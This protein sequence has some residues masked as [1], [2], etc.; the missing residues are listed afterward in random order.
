VEPI[1]AQGTRLKVQKSKETNR[2]PCGPIRGL[3]RRSVEMRHFILGSFFLSVVFFGQAFAG[4]T[5][6]FELLD[7][8]IITGE[9][10]SY[11][12]G[13]F[14]LKSEILGTVRIEDTN[15]RAIRSKEDRGISGDEVLALQEKMMGNEEIFAMILSLQNDPEFREVLQDP[16]IMSAVSSGDI[17]ALLSNQKFLK[18]L[19]NPA[20][21]DIGKMIED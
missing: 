11:N 9:I 7:G 18:L 21:Q 15:I 14:I 19:E 6:T 20:I 16:D 3:P 13:T 12:D 2:E 5:K 17:N 4:E 10:I 1:T 8:S